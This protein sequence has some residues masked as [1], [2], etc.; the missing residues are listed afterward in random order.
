MPRLGSLTQSPRQPTMLRGGSI[1]PLMKHGF[2]RLE[3]ATEAEFAHGTDFGLPPGM[4]AICHSW[5]GLPY[6]K[7][8]VFKGSFSITGVSRDSGGTPL[9]FCDVRLFKASAFDEKVAQT[10]SDGSGNY[11]F[12]V[13]DNASNYW[14]A[15]YESAT[16]RAGVSGRDL[17]AI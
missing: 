7:A 15:M 13:P 4:G 16:P 9:A 14:V 10:T 17:V 5:A 8:P 6:L 1:V 3:A 11:T 2:V 12:S